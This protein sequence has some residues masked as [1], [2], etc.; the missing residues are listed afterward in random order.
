MTLRFA[1]SL[2]DVAPQTWPACA[3]LLDAVERVARVPVTLLVVPDYHGGGLQAFHAGY[4]RALHERLRGGDELALHGWRHRDTQPLDHGLID[5]LRRTRLTAME[6]EFS[7]LSKAQAAA[8]LEAG[9]RWFGKQGWP[10][11]GFVAPAWLLSPGAWE[12][13]TCFPFAWTTTHGAMHLLPERR[14]VATRTFVYSAR[15]AL[16][17]QLCLLRNES[18]RRMPQ[19]PVVRLAL[20]PA[21]AAHAAFVAHAQAVL[22]SLLQAGEALTKSALAQALR[23][24]APVR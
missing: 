3:R 7:A 18:L 10:L 8:L 6:G 23:E 2:H 16:R 17:R 15:S 19:P 11:Q 1:V 24:A 22:R 20:H 14:A 4:R 12:A 5:T 13:L 21:D 9:V